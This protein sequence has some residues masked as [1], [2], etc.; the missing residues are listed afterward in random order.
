MVDAL[1]DWLAG[2][3]ALAVYPVLMLLSALENVFPPVPADVAVALGAWLSRRGVV[4]A[5]LLGLLC[6]LANCASAVGVYALARRHGEALLRRRWARSLLPEP[7][8]ETIREAYRRHGV[9]GIFWSRFLP[10]VRAGVLPFAGIAGMPARR[11]LPPAL[12]ASAIWYAGLV[13][14]GSGFGL[15]WEDVRRHVADANRVLGVLAALAATAL[16][17][18]IARRSRRSG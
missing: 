7:V 2:L 9:G 3:P 18:W 8:M 4:A 10:G 12:L 14:L 1:L 6:W 5:P 11:A 13:A 16:A 15:E 17:L